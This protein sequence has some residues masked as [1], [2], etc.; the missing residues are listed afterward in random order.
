MK[1][2]FLNNPKWLAVMNPQS[3]KKKGGRSMARRRKTR[4]RRTTTPAAP[5]RHYRSNPRRRRR[6]PFIYLSSRRR[7]RYR[8]NPV[9]GSGT[10]VQIASA[11]VGYLTA[12]LLANMIPVA[13]TSKVAQYIKE[14]AAVTVGSWLL[15]RFAGRKLGT[16]F[17]TGGVLHIAVD[18]LQT[19]VPALGGS[20]VGYYFPPDDVLGLPGAGESTVLSPG[21]AFNNGSVARYESRF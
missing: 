7:R 8:R 1:V 20:G 5:R 19:Y 9:L 12:P 14:G 17:L 16:A 4:R 11:G 6:N 18:A 15:G 2:P 10:L 21:D 3:R 13:T